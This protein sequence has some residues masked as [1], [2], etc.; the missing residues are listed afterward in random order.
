MQEQLKN[1]ESDQLEATLI[2]E[3]D[4]PTIEKENKKSS[5]PKTQEDAIAF[6]PDLESSKTIETNNAL[7][8]DRVAQVVAQVE[9]LQNKNEVVTEEDI[10]ALLVKA[11]HE[12][13]LNDLTKHKK[14]D[15]AAL[16]EVVEIEIETTFRDKVYE[17]L[18]EGYQ[19]VR[20]AVVSRKN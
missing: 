2:A 20:T 6:E 18:G 1:E 8:D 4:T 14:V 5:T 12:I 3:E 16:L 7:E 17:A 10:D 19:K 15:A 13:T 11:Q 9:A